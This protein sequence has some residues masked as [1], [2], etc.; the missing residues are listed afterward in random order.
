VRV[1]LSI[2]VVLAALTFANASHA[3]AGSGP[4]TLTIVTVPRLAGVHF[5]FDGRTYV[6]GPGGSVRI[7]TTNGSHLLQILTPKMHAPGLRSTFVRWGDNQY[8][9]TRTITIGHNTVLDAGF[10]QSVLVHFAF[11]DLGGHRVLG[12]VSRVTL[13]NTLGSRVS[14]VPSWPIWLRAT[15]LA[16]RFTG[17]EPTYIE[18]SIE[19]ALVN[20]SNVVNQSQQRFYP[21]KTRHFTASLLLYSA[22]VS[23]R[24]FLF[25]TS[26]GSRVDL[27]YPGG[28]KVP[29]PLKGGRLLLAS[30]PRGTYQIHV[31]A[32]G[33]V[34]LVSLALSKNQVLD[35]KVVSYLDM[36]LL[37]V[38]VLGSV[39]VLILVPR[40]FLRLRLRSLGSGKSPTPDDLEPPKPLSDPRKKLIDRYMPD[41]EESPPVVPRLPAPGPSRA[42]VPTNEEKVEQ[43]LRKLPS[44]SVEAAV[45]S[46]RR[47]WDRRAGLPGLRRPVRPAAGEELAEKALKGERIDLINVY[48]QEQPTPA[49]DTESQVPQVPQVPEPE[50]GGTTPVPARVAPATT[51]EAA[52]APP[53]ALRRPAPEPE[54]HA[55]PVVEEK[56]EPAPSA[57]QD[58]VQSVEVQAVEESPAPASEEMSAPPRKRAAPARR[59]E[60]AAATA[61]KSATPAR[62]R[63]TA[64]TSRK[65]AAKAK[66][67]TQSTRKRA[68]AKK[69]TTAT[70]RKSTTP[71]KQKTQAPAK[72]KEALTTKKATKP[73]ATRRRAPLKLVPATPPEEAAS[74]GEATPA[75]NG[76]A[77]NDDLS[78]VWSDLAATVEALQEDLKKVCTAT[79]EKNRSST[80]SVPK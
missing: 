27:I 26:A 62:R 41:P 43:P 24:D 63:S 8:R 15:N 52:K 25:G 80:D 17:L 78:H 57:E 70:N 11:V 68:P 54:L 77:G 2:A 12:R 28:N 60:P 4:T 20:G 3:A 39:T 67:T 44:R 23:V 30:L 48:M 73:A 10:Q 65:P 64:A 72:Q 59:K 55:A 21:A 33:Y 34:P 47:R 61:K 58:A 5:A 32:G 1:V 79:A 38:L 31:D 53:A 6:T 40:P 37:L 75:T 35:V 16:R 76:A 7:D 14:F 71:A 74:D 50:A 46:L 13:S 49:Q 69:S 66:T 36:L 9:A 19:R 42:V 51:A 18:Y 22:R 29:Y 56:P 45:A